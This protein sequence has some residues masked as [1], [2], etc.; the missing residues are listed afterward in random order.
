[1]A[2]ASFPQT[3]F[4]EGRYMGQSA[5]PLIFWGGTEAAKPPGLVFVCPVCGDAWARTIIEGAQ[6]ITVLKAC[7]KHTYSGGGLP[8]S[9]WSEHYRGFPATFPTEVLQ[10]ELLRH[11]DWWEKAHKND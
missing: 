8:G 9:L 10:W 4:I 11:L 7:R 1:M 6:F 2:A 5:A 3:F